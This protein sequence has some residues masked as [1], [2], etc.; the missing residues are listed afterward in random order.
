MTSDC[1]SDRRSWFARNRMT[2]L[3][4]VAIAVYAAFVE[5]FWGWPALL[6]QWSEIGLGAAF[7]ALVLLI[8][9]YFVRCYRIYDYFPNETTGRFLPLFRVTQVHNLLNIMLPF[10]AGETSFPL[11]MRSEFSVPLARGT[12]ALLVMRLLDLH[13]LLVVAAIGLVIGHGSAALWGLWLAAFVSPLLFFLLKDHAV[14]LSRR[15]LPVKLD[16]LVDELEAG[17]PLNAPAFLRAWGMTILNWAVKVIVLA[18]VLAVMGVAPLAACFGG[19]LGG[20]L[21][22][23]LPMHAPAGVGTYPAAIA[24]GAISFGAPAGRAGLEQLATAGVNAHLLIIVSA[25][26]GTMLSMVLGRRR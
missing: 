15:L 8:A 9:T 18:W 1:E 14:A 11:L 19:A 7:S 16:A 5:W 25:V 17:L 3:S 13:A 12:A 22:S 24:A 23:V 26:A 21:S 4:A 20:E 2:M 6:A 10:R